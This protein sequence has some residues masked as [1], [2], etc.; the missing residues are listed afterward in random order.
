M[1]VDWPARIIKVFQ[2]DMVLV[3]PGPPREIYQLDTDWFRLKLRE[4]E[5]NENGGA[6]LYTHDHNTT[7]EVSGAILA[8]VVEI[9]NGYQVEFED[10]QYAVNLVGSNNNIS[11]VSVVNQVSIRPSN[12]A[13]LQD[14][15]SLQAASFLGYVALK[16]SSLFSGT[17][18]PVGTRGFPVN[19][20]A[21]AIVIATDRGIQNISI[22][23]SMT[24]SSGDWQDG[25]NFVGDNAAAVLLTVDTTAEV[26]NCE[27]RN[28]TLQGVLDGNN[29]VRDCNVL[30]LEYV[31]GILHQCSLNGT[32]VIAPGTQASIF[33]CYS[34]VAGGGP[35]QYAHI[36]AGG[37]G[38]LA[39]RNYS[40]GLHLANVTGSGDISMDFLSGRL[41]AE[42]TCTAGDAY[43]R[44]ICNVTDDSNGM[45]LHDDTIS[46]SIVT[47]QTDIGAVQID[48]S[49]AQK[50]L[51]NK[52]TTN[53]LT[54]EMTI[55]DD[56]GIAVLLT[57]KVW[58]NVEGS[59]PY[60]GQGLERQDRLE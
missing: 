9:I 43:A 47:I 38:S 53:P 57:A 17:I 26:S 51:R 45:T 40:G 52:K 56:D 58:A 10:G 5:A 32:I 6:Y 36:D 42:N 29:V 46:A 59:L 24:L 55:Y 8:R 60:T 37:S 12:S 15:N 22:M 4:L 54:G 1:F 23:E 18:F 21:D 25:I 16:P 50:I 33:D 3:D 41:V 31:A 19:N 44:G 30:D 27:F 49:M 28:L 48:M 20:V 2:P 35:G 14:L 39:L 34:N 7:V 13:G 11:D